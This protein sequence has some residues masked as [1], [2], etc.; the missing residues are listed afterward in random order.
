M[1]KN[2]IE[3]FI[4]ARD[5]GTP[6]I[7]IRTQDPT[8]AIVAIQQAL[9][10]KANVT[11]LMSWDLMH[12]LQGLGTELST[13][14]VAALGTASG[15]EVGASV[16]LTIALAMLDMAKTAGE[17][18]GGIEDIVCFLY[19]P[20]LMWE[21]D[22]KIIQGIANLRNDFKAHGN[23]L[24]H[25]IGIGDDIP[26]I[27][28]ADTL[29]L[30]QPLPNS[31]DLA[32]IVKDT[33]SHAYNA[34]PKRFAKCKDAATPGI[35]RKAVDAGIGLPQF[36]FEQSVATCLNRQT[37]TLDLPM[38]WTS[39]ED[40]ISRK[41][42]LSYHKSRETLADMYGRTAWVEYGKAYMNGPYRPRLLVRMDEIQRQFAGSERQDDGTKGNLMGDFLT[43]VNDQNVTCTLDIGLSGT[44]KSWGPYCLGGEFGVPVLNYSIS[45]MEHKHVGESSRHQREA[46]QTMEALA[47]G[48][49][50]IWLVASANR[51]DGLPPEL[52]SR[53]QVGGIFFF[54][55][56][57]DS[58]KEG[59]M[60]LKIKSYGLEANQEIPP[61]VNW[62]ERDINNCCLRAKKF[63]MS[64]VKAAKYIVP[65]MTSHSS[66]ME[67]M[68]HEASGRFLS[69][70]HEGLYQYSKPA[71]ATVPADGRKF[72]S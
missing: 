69:A 59:V 72:R 12:G 17:I 65:L 35:V 33:F 22:P 15:G 27:I 21:S 42:G 64:L 51:M 5:A 10:D 19:N 62:T 68:R 66:E 31:E 34:D 16:E 46:H 67:K 53:F 71:V 32:K 55:L 61:M 2:F 6:F 56:P 4:A 29:V 41:H 25:L 50:N 20:Q 45:S 24:V 39:K 1:S 40:I 3:H 43:W 49:E 36:P 60:A 7:A 54:D 48:G 9:G 18:E 52:V 70:A 8:S 58:D 44:S 23:V 28:A 26:S 30:D 63:G 14:A 13:N 37:G 47:G 11:P 38:L 57:T